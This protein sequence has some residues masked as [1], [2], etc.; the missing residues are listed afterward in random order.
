MTGG[1]PG[2][3]F[4][5]CAS[6]SIELE[7]TLVNSPGP[8]DGMG[9]GETGAAIGG[10][11]D[12]IGVAEGSAFS[13]RRSWVKPPAAGGVGVAAGGG[14]GMSGG[15][16]FTGAVSSFPRAWNSCVNP[17]CAGGVGAGFGALPNGLAPAADAGVE[18]WKLAGGGDCCFSEA[19]GSSCGAFRP[20]I[21]E[22]IC[23]NEP[24]PDLGGAAAGSN[25][26]AGCDGAGADS[27]DPARD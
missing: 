25:V 10:G 20:P 7:M 23:V 5:P 17:P 4:C 3:K 12:C 16:S 27:F 8:L 24:G 13:V 11:A 14:E 2:A 18:D 9:G 1:L 26:A 6:R 15:G 21:C 19:S 22:N